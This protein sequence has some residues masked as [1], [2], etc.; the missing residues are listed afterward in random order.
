[1]TER[2]EGERQDDEGTN[3]RG[4]IGEEGHGGDKDTKRKSPKHTISDECAT[5]GAV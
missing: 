3:A 4:E 5:H 2:E 1:M